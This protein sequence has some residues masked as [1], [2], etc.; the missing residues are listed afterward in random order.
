MFDLRLKLREL[1]KKQ[2]L[3]NENRSTSDRNYED[4]HTSSP[5][6]L[7]VNALQFHHANY[8]SQT[9]LGNIMSQNHIATTVC[10]MLRSSTILDH[11][12]VGRLFKLFLDS[13]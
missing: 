11:Y 10:L 9:S 12:F 8:C 4:V 2:I 6:H 1:K 3:P 13:P 7:N 5:L